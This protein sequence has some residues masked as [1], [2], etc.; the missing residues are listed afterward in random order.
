MSTARK[1][2][3]HPPPPQTPRI[4]HLPRR[5][6]RSRTISSRAP[7]QRPPPPP[8]P[9]EPLRNPTGRLEVLFD[10][11]RAFLSSSAAGCE[12][13][14]PKV[15]V[16]DD[17]DDGR[18]G[19]GDREAAVPAESEEEK[20]RFQAE[21]LRAE[22]NFLRTERDIALKKLERE[23]VDTESTLKSAVQTLVSGRRKIGRDGARQSIG[24]N[25]EIRGLEAK[26]QEM[27]TISGGG[28]LRGSRI[29]C[30]NF[31]RQAEHLRRRLEKL[32]S[33]DP[34]PTEEEEE[35]VREIRVVPESRSSV[36]VER[37]G[38]KMEGLSK[39]M[40][41]RVEESLETSKAIKEGERCTGRC[42]EVVRRIAEQVK[43]ETEQWSEM[44][45]MLRRVKA[46]MD[47]LRCSRDFW[48]RL[49]DHSHHQLQSLHSSA[50][51]W[52]QRARSLQS[53]ATKLRERVSELQIELERSKSSAGGSNC[54]RITL[55]PLKRPTCPLKENQRPLLLCRV[56]EES[57]KE[58]R[59]GRSPFSDIGNH[60]RV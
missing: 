3:W 54:P 40:L 5:T 46:E 15:V 52:R 35:S 53:E 42:K 24:L 14:R 30:R 2:K 7:P 32:R 36:S 48:A 57:H 37:L 26:L 56:K 20:W 34:D 25:E 12:R 13:R 50:M 58:Q 16:D 23:R 55:S 11:E 28:G 4:L 19:G 22:C 27:K 41:E 59:H 33:S 10:Q 21:I 49:A 45:G 39:G 43:L 8:P 6:R 31:D 60:W 47:G 29:G 9:A 38:K 51:E 44:Q 17:D 18:G 1:T